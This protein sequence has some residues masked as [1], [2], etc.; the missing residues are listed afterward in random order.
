MLLT[1]MPTY[2]SENLRFDPTVGLVIVLVVMVIMM[3]LTVLVGY[4]SD[5]I[6]RRRIIFG[7]SLGF[8]V[9]AIPAFLIIQSVTVTAIFG[10]LLLLGLVLICFTGTMPA[11][12]PA[13]FPTHIRYTGLSI[14]FN[15]AVAILGGTTPIIVAG[16]ITATGSLMM[17]AYYLMF[18]ALC[19]GVAALFM[20][21]TARQSLKGSSPTVESDAEAREVASAR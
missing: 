10:G 11:T 12:L 9:L 16:L 19:G 18:A 1:Y 4:L 14:G 3:G 17:P 6:G 7:G 13:L 20:G 2:L 21:E 8:L 5:R 15:V